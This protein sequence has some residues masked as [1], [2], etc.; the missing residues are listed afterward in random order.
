MVQRERSGADTS[1]IIHV[2]GP[3]TF[4]LFAET[5]YFAFFHKTHISNWIVRYKEINLIK[6]NFEAISL[7]RMDLINY[8][9]TLSFYIET[10]IC[11]FCI[12]STF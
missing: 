3:F 11:N 8:E 4:S 6:L 12:F 1:S 7:Y 9:F 2:A 10:F 5:I